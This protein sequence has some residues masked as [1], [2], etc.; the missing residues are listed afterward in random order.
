M[1]LILDAGEGRRAGYLLLMEP[2]TRSVNISALAP[3]AK[4]RSHRLLESLQNTHYLFPKKTG[5]LAEALS[6]NSFLKIYF[7][8]Y[9]FI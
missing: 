6:S 7:V 1:L 4:P 2:S 3:V 8:F 5:V 9:N